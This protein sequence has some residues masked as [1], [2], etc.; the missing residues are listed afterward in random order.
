MKNLYKLNPVLIVTLLLYCSFLK[1]QNLPSPIRYYPLDHF[2]GEEIINGKN[3]EVRGNYGLATDRWGNDGGAISFSYVASYINTP[4][5]FTPAEI[6]NK[7]FSISFWTRLDKSSLRKTDEV[8]FSAEDNNHN[9]SLFGLTA[10]KLNRMVINRYVPNNSQQSIDYGLP[11]AGF[12]VWL[13]DPVTFGAK[14]PLIDGWCF[15]TLSCNKNSTRVYITDLKGTTVWATNYFPPQDLTTATN[16]SIGT[17]SNHQESFGV[18]DDFKVYADSLSI[19]QVK[20]LFKKETTPADPIDKYAVYRLKNIKSGKYLAIDYDNGYTKAII[21]EENNAGANCLWS[22]DFNSPDKNFYITNVIYNQPLDLY[23]SSTSE[24]AAIGSY[25]FNYHT[26]QTWTFRQMA[27]G[28]N[29]Y[30]IRNNAAISKCMAISSI[31]ENATI[32]SQSDKTDGVDKWILEK[33]DLTPIT[34]GTY[35]LK[36]RGVTTENQYLG[37]ATYN[38]GNDIITQMKDENSAGHTVLWK[39][40]PTGD[41]FYKLS[42]NYDKVLDLQHS[43]WW[44]GKPIQQHDNNN[45]NAQRW[46]FWKDTEGYYRIASKLTGKFAVVA[47]P[48]VANSQVYQHGIAANNAQWQFERV[49]LQA[50]FSPDYKY[51]I[52]SWDLNAYDSPPSNEV[53]GTPSPILDYEH[54]K[55]RAVDDGGFGGGLYTVKL[56]YF[57]DSN[58]WN[59]RGASF[60]DN[61]N[62]ILYPSSGSGHT[63]EQFLIFK[64]SKGAV[65]IVNKN[66]GKFIAFGNAEGTGGRYYLRQYSSVTDDN[67][68]YSWNINPV[69]STAKTASSKDIKN[70]SDGFKVYPNPSHGEFTVEFSLEQDSKLSLMLFDEL[71][72][73]IFTENRKLSKGGQNITMRIPSTVSKGIYFLRT[74]NDITGEIVSTKKIVLVK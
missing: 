58:T 42:N 55:M 39:I 24:N 27:L 53:Q 6:P 40:E 2:N 64:N 3:G 71:G 73:T 23:Q 43:D 16:W 26:N 36:N 38:K 44:D 67:Y 50:Y 20:A 61:T 74:V 15:V 7:R 32:T 25:Y 56:D 22:I 49:D 5:F 1:A 62:I 4:A 52:K 11:V 28:T 9:F 72:K 59:V 31:S 48:N 70:T 54:W 47:D 33:V 12:N 29:I 69:W 35:R 51:Q 17:R 37:L 60:Y 65:R 19:D 10:D 41:S 30:R 8:A 14:S 21:R 18:M 46:F 45:S 68:R 57:P 66:S 63:N 13:W 34:K